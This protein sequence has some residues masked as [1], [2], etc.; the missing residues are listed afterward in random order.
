MVFEGEVRADHGLDAHGFG[1]LMES[2]LPIH[3]V[4]ITEGQGR[5][6][7]FGR[8]RGQLFGQG[9]SLQKGKGAAHAQFNVISRRRHRG[10]TARS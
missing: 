1:G 3:S 4:T 2:W 5:I 9:C 6:T 8:A 7:Q 10:T